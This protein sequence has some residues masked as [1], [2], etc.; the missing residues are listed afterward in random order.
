MFSDKKLRKPSQKILKILANNIRI[1]RKSKGLSQEEF[2]DEC[3]LHRTYIGAIE[4]CERNVTIGTLE[5][6]AKT[7]QIQISELLNTHFNNG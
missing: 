5:A 3:S 7:M 1:Y 6:I 2:A 4:R